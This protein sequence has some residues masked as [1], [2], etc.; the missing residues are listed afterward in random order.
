M[1]RDK[2]RMTQLTPA[3]TGRSPVADLPLTWGRH[4]GAGRKGPFHTRRAP[5][6]GA[7]EEGGATGAGARDPDDGRPA[8]RGVR[9]RPGA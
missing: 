3:I 8:A 6:V 1:E 9:S 4:P 5:K 2:A 7:D